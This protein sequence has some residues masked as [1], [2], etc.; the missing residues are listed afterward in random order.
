M[1]E[2]RTQRVSVA[3]REEL[4]EIVGF[5]LDDPRLFEVTVT[6]TRVSP[7]GRYAHVKVALGGD[8]RQQRESLAALDRARH[9]LR[10]ELAA[11]LSLRHVP[12]L[13][14]EQDRNPDVDSRIDILLKRAKKSR[15]K[16]EN[17]P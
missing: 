9:Y 4:T 16:I 7:D 15:G 12:E 3:V 2:R 6:E 5:E 8:E 1:D 17:Q 14:F 13:H 10:H 11:R